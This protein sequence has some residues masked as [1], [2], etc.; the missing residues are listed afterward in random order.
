MNCF[1]CQQN[2]ALFPSP[3]AVEVLNLSAMVTE[4][5]D[6]DFDN[7]WARLSLSETVRGMP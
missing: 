4:G 2:D 5:A 3:V 1:W 6:C 7:Q